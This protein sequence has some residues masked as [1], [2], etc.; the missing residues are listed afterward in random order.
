M[1]VNSPVRKVPVRIVHAESSLERE[2]RAYLPQSSDSSATVSEPPSHTFSLSAA[3]RP[4]PSLFCTY[5]RQ[6]DQDHKPVLESASAGALH[7]KEDAKREEL[8]RDIMGRDK[9]LVDIL[10]QSGRMTTM[11]LMEGL[12]PTE[13]QLL[14]GALQRRR[15]SSSSR[16]LTASPRSLDRCVDG[17]FQS[18]RHSVSP[19]VV[20]NSHY[21]YL[22]SSSAC[23]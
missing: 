3:E 22:Y 8:A 18:Y 6:A 15:A 14:E 9:S 16:L 23:Q 1:D 12:F 4:A 11:D 19:L 13:E 7:S 21:S 17:V 5:S 20:K 2:G 10:D